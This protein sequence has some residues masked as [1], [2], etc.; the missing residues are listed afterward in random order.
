MAVTIV[1]DQTRFNWIATP[2]TDL[3]QI[4]AEHGIWRLLTVKHSTASRAKRHQ[5]SL[6]VE[7]GVAAELKVVNLRVPQAPAHL[8]SQVVSFEYLPGAAPGTLWRPP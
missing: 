4:L 1:D 3:F 6:K 2:C 5:I 7:S 8:A